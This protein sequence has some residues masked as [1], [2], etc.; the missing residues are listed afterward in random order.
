MLS[1]P[2]EW[3]CFFCLTHFLCCAL[4]LVPLYPL[5]IVKWVSSREKGLS[6][7]KNREK[8]RELGPENSSGGWLPSSFTPAFHP[9]L[10]V[11]LRAGMLWLLSARVLGGEGSV[12]CSANSCGCAVLQ[13]S[14]WVTYLGSDGM[15]LVQSYQ[16]QEGKISSLELLH[17]AAPISAAQAPVSHAYVQCMVAV[18]AAHPGPPQVERAGSHGSNL[19]DSFSSH[20]NEMCSC[21]NWYTSS[22]LLLTLLPPICLCWDEFSHS[23]EQPA[24]NIAET[25][26]FFSFSQ[27]IEQ[28]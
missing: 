20:F 15:I 22:E 17:A 18:H 7:C 5:I 19:L 23:T 1:P 14:P 16:N 27:A 12:N 3:R 9:L 13:D 6:L 28:K 26:F 8:G 10:E 25:S 11:S 2:L 21:V 4:V 24:V